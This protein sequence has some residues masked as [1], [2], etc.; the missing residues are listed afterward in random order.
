AR[1]ARHDPPF[2]GRA[3]AAQERGAPPRV[4]RDCLGRE[5]QDSPA[6]P[7]ARHARREAPPRTSTLPDSPRT[8]LPR[9]PAPLP[10]PRTRP[11]RA[12]RPSAR[13]RRPARLPAL[14]GGGTPSD[15]RLADQIRRRFL[16]GRPNEAEAL[17]QKARILENY[18]QVFEAAQEAGRLRDVEETLDYVTREITAS[19]LEGHVSLEDAR[20]Y[21]VPYAL[22]SPAFL[23]R[24]FG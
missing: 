20:P 22:N 3:R 13:P 9:D 14:L 19:G 12:L 21:F 1:P 18:E 4:H 5:G 2:P 16:A 7:P 11:P 10:P 24:L 8:R 17:Y 23:R 6:R 15:S